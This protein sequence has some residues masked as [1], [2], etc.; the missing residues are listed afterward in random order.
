MKTE[1][2]IVNL[3]LTQVEKAKNADR[4]VEYR[5]EINDQKNKLADQKELVKALEGRMETILLELDS[6]K[7]DHLMDLIPRKN[8]LYTPPRMEWVDDKEKVWKSRE[9]SEMEKQTTTQDWI[10]TEEGSEEKPALK[11]A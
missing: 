7:K 4:L 5:A 3:P 10:I 9:L 6:G 11:K 8:F 1:S 2:V